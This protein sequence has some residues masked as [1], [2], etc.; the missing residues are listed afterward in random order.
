MIKLNLLD[1]LNPLNFF[2]MIVIVDYG[3]GNLGSIKNMLQ[4]IGFDAVISSDKEQIAGAGKLILP[5]VGSF[6]QGMSNLH[7]R[8]LVPVL[9]QRVLEDQVP[10]LGICLG[11]QLFGTK[12]EEGALPG[13][14]WLDQ[15]SKKFN[16]TGDKS[17]PVPHLGWEYVFSTQHNS[18]LLEGFDEEKRFYFAHS[19]YVKSN[20]R[21]EVILEADYI[22]K[23]DA[24][25][26]KEHIVGV[27]FHP[28]KSHQFGMR[29]L[30]NF[31]V[32]F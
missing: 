7:E 24:A 26:Q 3:L 10:I 13:L 18:K 11:M 6:D 23:F 29:L 22:H 12:S 30:T 15:E 32:N 31:V 28:E 1:F 27:Q 21:Q 14:S 25:V 2:S 8:G 9:N 5:G 19:Y 17:F 20:N 4:Y 16:P